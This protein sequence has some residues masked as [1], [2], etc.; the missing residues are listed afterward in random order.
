MPKSIPPPTPELNRLRAAAALLPIIEA[1][2]AESR[3][4]IERASVMTSFC[5]SAAEFKPENPE[6][7][8]L[9]VTVLSGLQRLK[10]ARLSADSP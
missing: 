1:G 5:E 4:S 8:K 2:L 7:I 3:L 6:E 9:S 10:K